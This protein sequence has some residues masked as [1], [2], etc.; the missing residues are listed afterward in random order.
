[1]SPKMSRIFINKSSNFQR[2]N[3]FACG[4]LSL[5]ASSCHILF[6]SHFCYFVRLLP[7]P[8]HRAGLPVALPLLHHRLQLVLLHVPRSGE[9]EPH[10]EI[11]GHRWVPSTKRVCVATIQDN[12]YCAILLYEFEPSAESPL[13]GAPGNLYRALLS[14][15]YITPL[16][17]GRLPASQLFQPS[18]ASPPPPPP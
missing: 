18:P 5:F 10:Q 14:G 12:K 7:Q 15:R 16:G 8:R 6:N 9:R 2:W 3:P 4:G 17:R 11:R 1:M 13:H